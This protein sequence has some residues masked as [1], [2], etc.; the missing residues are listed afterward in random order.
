LTILGIILSAALISGVG[1]IGVSFLEK[2]LRDTIDITGDYYATVSNINLDKIR[3]H[4]LV[5]NIG[6][7]NLIGFAD[8]KFI[9]NDK[10][11]LSEFK[12]YNI[13]S[14]DKAALEM[15]PIKIKSGRMPQ[16]SNEV[17]IGTGT[18]QFLK[19]PPNIGEKI[20]LEIT[21]GT[22]NND[23]KLI[24]D[25]DAYIKEFKVV[26]YLDSWASYPFRMNAIT[27]YNKNDVRKDNNTIYI[28]LKNKS[29]IKQNINQ[30]VQDVSIK[31]NG[32]TA[33]KISYN[34]KVLR[35]LL[36][37]ED[38]TN[39][40]LIVTLGFLALIVVISMIAVIYNTFN[41]S[42]FER[43]SQFGLLRCVGSTRSQIRRL[44]FKEATILGGI[45]I[46]IGILLGTLAMKA[47]FSFLSFMAPNLPYGDL[48]LIISPY[49][50]LASFLMSF[51]A[52]YLSAFGPSRKASFISPIE[53][54]KS[55]GSLKK[56]KI[57]KVSSAKF[58][59]TLFGAEGWIAQKNLGRNRIRFA[60]TVFS[61]IISIV[62]FIVFSSFIDLAYKTGINDIH[63]QMVNFTLQN[64]V[65]YHGDVAITPEEI[66]TFKEL[67]E[68]KTVFTYYKQ[69]YKVG[70]E[71]VLIPKERVNNQLKEFAGNWF[72]E[73]LYADEY[74]KFDKSHVIALG[75]EGTSVLNEYVKF[76]SIDIDDMNRENGVIVVS[77]GEIYNTVT[78]KK[79]VLKT[80]NLKVGDMIRVKIPDSQEGS[81]VDALEEYKNYKVMAI[82]EQ[83]IWGEKFNE[84]G[85]INIYTTEKIYKELT[86]PNKHPHMIMIETKNGMETNLLKKHLENFVQKNPDIVFNDYDE[87]MKEY[88][89]SNIIISIFVYGFFIIIAL[90][91]CV[92][93]INTISTN[94]ILRTRELSILKAVG[95]TQKGIKKLICLE[96]IFYGITACILGSVLGCIL[97]F[98]LYKLFYGA[99]AVEWNMPWKYMFM[100][101]AGTL[102]VTLLSGY[103]PLKRINN[104]IIIQ[105]IRE[106]Q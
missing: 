63:N 35:L 22:T 81:T 95:M 85:G 69:W 93:I 16:N 100:A 36:Q 101:V 90:I 99:I 37:S 44:V 43:I 46:P 23:G 2:M 79:M 25:D 83:G 31:E 51:I 14:Y 97:S 88:Y 92:N 29:K 20:A 50:I 13:I 75:D 12:G 42:V 17:I 94:I 47:L 82:L 19:A 28:K 1:T 32:S 40:A 102:I 57:R 9:S 65:D 59:K 106:E 91:G 67:P 4:V 24:S 18:L 71:S 41:I 74:L 27:F 52:V 53:A 21:A 60:I 104:S 39:K 86:S 33:C 103:L 89:Q 3:R 11:E 64:K 54:V 8:K 49:I 30:I 34:N 10:G 6:V 73:Y 98:S 5:E 78:E 68:V 96:S 70:G 62:L 76:G 87:A 55:V 77:T 72:D 58:A 105:N 80:S 84:N 48:K 56:E 15:L 61:M 26:G 7:E 66:K 45:G 38:K